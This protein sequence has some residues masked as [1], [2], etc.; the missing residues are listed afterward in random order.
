MA[1]PISTSRNLFEEPYAVSDSDV[2]F[3]EEN[4]YVRFNDVLSPAEVAALKDDVDRA[5][6]QR[7]TF[8]RDLGAEERKAD[9]ESTDAH[10]SDEQGSEEYQILQMLNLWQHYPSVKKYVFSRRVAA[11]AARLAGSS[12]MRL[13]HDQCLV[14]PPHSKAASP[15]HQDQP[16]WPTK[17]PGMLSCWMALDDVTV[18]RGA[19]HFIPGSHRWGELPPM[20]F[21][22]DG[23]QLDDVLTD[24]QKQAWNPT[25]VELHAGS[26]T[27]HHGLTFHYTKPNTTDHIRRALVT[28]YIP[29]GITYAGDEKMETPFDETI[30][31]GKGQPLAGELFKQLL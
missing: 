13:Y 7:D 11:I 26:C 31:S 2:S 12:T 8:A 18:D 28:I 21:T 5:I 24:E 14:K 19:M 23:P 30:T 27:F 20:S 29:E 22:G 6:A 17:D 25:P 9:G 15:W 4:G 16:Y 1:A 3:F 10:E